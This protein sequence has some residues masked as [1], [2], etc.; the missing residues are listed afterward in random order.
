VASN[1][2]GDASIGRARG[3]AGLGAVEHEGGRLPRPDG[4]PRADAAAVDDL[5]R[6]RAERLSASSGERKS[7]PSGVSA[8]SWRARVV[9]AW[10]DV[11]DKAHLPEH[12][13]HPAD[14]VVASRRLAGTP[15]GA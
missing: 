4:D 2:G 9:E 5:E 11:D 10:S 1:S 8:T 12:G 13:E 3:L 6:Q 7:A 14:H 15:A